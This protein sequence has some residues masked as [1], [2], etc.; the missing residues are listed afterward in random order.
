MKVY[1][2]FK[3][4]KGYL[5]PK[6]AVIRNNHEIIEWLSS[7][8]I[9]Y[10]FNDKPN[11]LN[12]DKEYLCIGISHSYSGYIYTHASTISQEYIDQY[13]ID[14]PY[15]KLFGDDYEGFKKYMTWV[16]TLGPWFTKQLFKHV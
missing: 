9:Q 6:S 4:S 10:F 3:D 14:N 13:L 8:K 2:C 12:L 7:N 1:N 15:I 11:T 5:V 16:S